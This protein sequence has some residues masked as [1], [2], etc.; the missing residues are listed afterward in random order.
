MKFLPQELYVKIYYEYY[1][2]NKLDYDNPKDFNEKISWYKVFFRPKILNQLV[3]KY[4]VKSYVE[5]KVGN[6][7]LNDTI[8]VYDSVSKIDFDSLPNQFVIKGVHGFHFNLIVKDK[9]KLNLLKSKYLLKKWMNKNQYY[10]GGMEW[11]YKD[12][13]PLLLVEKYLEEM[14]QDIINDYKFFCF[15]GVPKFVQIDL[16]RGINNYRC[17]YDM[18]WNKQEF[19]TEQNPFYT[20]EVQKPSN[21][22]EMKEVAIK[23]AEKFP[24]VRVDLYSI[25]GK[26]VF[27]E[28]TFYPTDARKRF[29]PEE[30]NKIIGDYFVLPKIPEGQ[31]YITSI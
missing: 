26:T 14:G 11:A 8:G 23:L 4:H 17:Y 9:S 22:G 20:G 29:L 27:G 7:I 25:E 31:K 16:E 21:F 10:R 3:D 13:K 6:H 12:V 15:D 24:F 5:K 2:G 19:Y 1:S 18:D 30:Y 28:M